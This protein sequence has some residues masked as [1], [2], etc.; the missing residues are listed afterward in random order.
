LRYD[1]DVATPSLLSLEKAMVLLGRVMDAENNCSISELAAQIGVPRSTAF[2][3]LTSFQRT[4]LTRRLRRGCY[5]PGPRLLRLVHSDAQNRILRGVGRPILHTLAGNTGCTAQLGVFENAMVT[6]LLKSGTARANLFTREGTQL[7]AYCTAIGKVL[8]ASLPDPAREE[9]LRSGP[10]IRMTSN[11][12]MDLRKLEATL[13][14][15]AAQGF[16][17]DDAEM[18]ANLRCIAVPVRNGEGTVIAALS[19]SIR[20][21]HHSADELQIHLAAL[22]AA[23]RTLT[24][25]VGG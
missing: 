18:D 25:K 11:T 7:E 5:L 4:G 24:E 3:I 13:A 8:L 15:I 6:Y 17:T 10:F 12:V 21:A 14:R 20:K 2:R 22:N 9:Y 23:A 16:A 1:A 19:I